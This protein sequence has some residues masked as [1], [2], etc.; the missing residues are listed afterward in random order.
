MVKTRQRIR[1]HHANIVCEVDLEF[2]QNSVVI[3]SND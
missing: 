3:E 1:I 2:V